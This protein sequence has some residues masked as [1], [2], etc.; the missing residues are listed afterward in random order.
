MG[1]DTR[2]RT[3]PDD[4]TASVLASFEACSDPRLR[5]LMQAFVRHLHEF[6]VDVGL[7]EEE[8][9]GLRTWYTEED[10]DR[11][12]AEVREMLR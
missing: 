6:A 1:T 4:I 3:T 5:T 12:W 8:W 9:R 10:S 11:L 7:T 2:T